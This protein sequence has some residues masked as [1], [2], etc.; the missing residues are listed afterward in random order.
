MKRIN[1]ITAI[2]ALGLLIIFSNSCCE[3]ENHEQDNLKIA[4]SKQ[5]KSYLG[6]IKRFD[7][8]A[9]FYNLYSM[10]TDSAMGVLEN[11]DGLILTGGEDIFPAFY[12]KIEDTVLCGSFDIYRDSLEFAAIELALKLKIPILGICR[13]EQILNVS[14]DG[15]LY[16]DIPTKFDTTVTHRQKDWKNCYHEVN[17]IGMSKLAGISGLNN[18]IVNSNHH[19]GINKLGKNLKI[20]AYTTDSLPEAIE[21]EN[22]GNKGFLMAVQ[23]HPE[24]MDTLHPLSAPIAKEFLREADLFKASQV[25]Q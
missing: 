23:W 17:I 2:I 4:F 12:N 24:R 16:A 3:H 6:W 9:E 15:S 18:G 11:C 21:W 10:G 22:C 13:G 20:T 25:L 5:S 7:D 19:Q 8:N 1:S 14:Q